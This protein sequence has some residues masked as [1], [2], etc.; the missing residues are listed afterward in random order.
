ML[1]EHS[2]GLGRLSRREFDY[3]DPL[4][5]Q[6]ALQLEPANRRLQWP[7]G[8]HSQYTNAGAGL[9]SRVIEVVTDVEFDSWFEHSVLEHLAMHNASIRWSPELQSRLVQGYDRDLKTPIPYWHTLFRAFYDRD[10]PQRESLLQG[11]REIGELAAE[12]QGK[13]RTRR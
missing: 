9:L 1:L 12:W 6:D 4:S 3:P 11:A 8:L 5:L 13:L 2:S 10:Y 7:A